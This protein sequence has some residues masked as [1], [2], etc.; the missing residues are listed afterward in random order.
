[1]VRLPPTRVI[2]GGNKDHTYRYSQGTSSLVE[3]KKREDKLFKQI[4][5]H[6]SGKFQ[7]VN[8]DK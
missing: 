4:G 6:E 2:G 5:F 7:T 8:K 3:M 1:M